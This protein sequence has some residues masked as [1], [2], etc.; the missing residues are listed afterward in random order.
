MVVLILG[1]AVYESGNRTW[2]VRSEAISH[3][4]SFCMPAIH[5]CL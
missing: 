5:A 2:Q 1:A 4:R 3:V